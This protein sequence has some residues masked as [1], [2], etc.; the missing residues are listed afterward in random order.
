[1]ASSALNHRGGFAVDNKRIERVL[2]TFAAFAMLASVCLA[3]DKSSKEPG[4]AKV[5]MTTVKAQKTQRRWAKFLGVDVVSTNHVGMDMSL[6]PPGEFAMG[7]D[8]QVRL[9]RPYRIGTYEVTV[10]QFRQ[11][12]KD[13]DYQTEAEA[14]ALGGYTQSLQGPRRRSPENVWNCKTISPS[15][16]HPVVFVTRG[17]AARFCEWLSRKEKSTYRLPT[18]AEW[19]WACRA[20]TSTPY[21]FG[22]DV[23]LMDQHS[24]NR[25]NAEN[26]SHPVGQRAANAWGLHDMYGNAIE[27]VQDLSG[28]YPKMTA[29]DP[30]GPSDGDRWIMR[31]GS[32][33]DGPAPSHGRFTMWGPGLCMYHIG[34][35]VVCEIK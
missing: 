25:A 2:A 1:M 14:S 33:R 20:G 6:I 19:E 12:V 17:D 27:M 5:P 16:D 18:E 3:A 13:T 11:F 31:G 8:Y 4:M 22:T 28:P 15:E 24:W 9:T 32:L 29:E 10:G 7:E 21:Y 30:Q 34:F 26:C 23:R 35:R